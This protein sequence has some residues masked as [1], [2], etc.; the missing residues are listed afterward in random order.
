VRFNTGD[1]FFRLSGEQDFARAQLGLTG[2]QIAER[3]ERV[4][5]GK[6]AA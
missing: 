1:T 4:L 3:I 5:S 6:A 2:P